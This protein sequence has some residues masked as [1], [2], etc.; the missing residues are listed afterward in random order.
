MPL[1]C[2]QVIDFTERQ[3]AF[4]HAKK[5]TIISTSAR[6]CPPAAHGSS[7]CLPSPKPSPRLTPPPHWQAKKQYRLRTRHLATLPFVTKFWKGHVLK[8]YNLDR[9]LELSRA[10]HL[11]KHPALSLKR[12]RAACESLA[13]DMGGDL[14]TLRRRLLLHVAVFTGGEHKDTLLGPVAMRAS[15]PS[16]HEPSLPP[17]RQ[18]P[19][20]VFTQVPAR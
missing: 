9:V 18:C 6:A 16:A 2:Q 14:R 7:P 19:S 12:A 3:L 15:L 8:L 11:T 1:A 17:N 5:D 13:L 4:A 20:L 10:V